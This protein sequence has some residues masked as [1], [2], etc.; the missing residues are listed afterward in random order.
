MSKK[1]PTASSRAV[2]LAERKLASSGLT[3]EDATRFGIEILDGAGTQQL[4][5][6]FQ[7]LCSLKLNY[8]DLKGKPIA[9]W[10]QGPPFYRV[11]YLEQAHDFASITTAKER[12]YTQP[13]GTMPVAC[14]PRGV[15]W[16]KLAKDVEQPVIITE[17]ELKAMKSCKEGFPAIGL[18]GVYNWRGLTSGITWLA[19]LD[20][21]TW[22]RRHVYIVFDSDFNTNPQVCHALHELAEQLVTK[23]CFAHLVAL[24]Q[25]PGLEK[26]GL[27]DFLV[28]QNAAEQ[29]R[30]M[31][32]D[33]EPLGLAEPL[34]ALNE[35]FVYVANPGLI[36][37]QASSQKVSP[38]A[39][40]DHHQST[41]VY[42]ER[43]LRPNGT[44]S[45][46]PV[47]ASAAW[48]KWPLRLEA[49][50]L[51]YEPGAPTFAP[52]AVR[53]F[54]KNYNTWPGW[55]VAPKEGDVEPFLALVR[56][57]F[58]GAEEASLRW[59]LRWLA[60]PLQ[61]PGVKLFTSVVL[62]GIRHGTGKSLLGYTIGRIYGK[63]FTEIRQGDLHGNFNEWAENKQLVLG[64][65][66][67]GGDKRHDAEILKTMITQREL[68]V[69]VKFLPSYVV[70][71][72]INYIFTSNHP[73]AFFIEDDDRR[74]FVHEV[75]V[76]PLS[77]EFYVAYDLWLDGD[78][79]EALFHYLLNLE[80][81]DFNPA[82]PAIR[83]QAKDR[84]IANIQSDLGSWCRQLLAT[85]DAVLKL[86]DM[87]LSKDLFLSKEL[88]TIY[89][90][91]G[92]TRTTAGGLGRE[93]SKCGVRQVC[94]GSP[95]RLP[96]G[97]QGRYYIIRNAET[98]LTAEPAA[99]VK[100]LTEWQKKHDPKR[101]F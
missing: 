42:Q 51:T 37:D 74:F 44:I 36:V 5:E 67:A 88:L 98:W 55:G 8:F 69:N 2:E 26:T 49:G 45:Y 97:S 7:P 43:V 6:Q 60:Y 19:S 63:N 17:G 50:S 41:Q 33:A 81:G 66:V 56:H 57:I 10:P 11:R 9:D 22:P 4:G 32:S 87:V 40:K 31:L 61:H 100:H 15:E 38:T 92:K 94:D 83:T 73:D 23:G 1:K 79:A 48:L 80:L 25:V 34:W 93:L 20:L 91:T 47:A 13:R 21:I 3:L 70:P 99:V 84:M 89:D 90:P 95:V 53:P 96:D 46:K 28:Q 68:R 30:E 39:F 86:G 27:D 18:G 85:P 64:D 101:K 65:D 82:A 62:H 76:G 72:C 14:Y 29:F 52:D 12:R 58:T 71:D 35:R 77:E 24:P 59:F 54:V 78:G 75:L 16:E